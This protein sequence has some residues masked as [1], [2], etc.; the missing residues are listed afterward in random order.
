MADHQWR[1]SLSVGISPAGKLS[2]YRWPAGRAPSSRSSRGWKRT[3]PLT[4]QVLR[5]LVKH[6]VARRQDH[7]GALAYELP[8]DRQ[9]HAMTGAGYRHCLSAIG[10]TP[11]RGTRY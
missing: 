11:V 7:G 5:R 2:Q 6:H 4:S 1:A 3:V 9:P 8:H 10:F